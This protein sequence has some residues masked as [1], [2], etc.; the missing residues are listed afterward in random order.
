MLLTPPCNSQESEL[1]LTL[2]TVLLLGFSFYPRL[3]AGLVGHPCN[4]LHN[5]QPKYRESHMQVST[6]SE[7]KGGKKGFSGRN[8]I[9]ETKKL[10]S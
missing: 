4:H 9:T 8:L 2:A 5:G 1:Q 10:N 7:N 6:S 3:T